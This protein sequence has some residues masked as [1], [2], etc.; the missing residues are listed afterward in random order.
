[1]KRREVFEARV[2]VFL[3]RRW[4]ER[5]GWTTVDVDVFLEHGIPVE[6]AKLIADTLVDPVTGESAVPVDWWPKLIHPPKLL[7]ARKRL[8]TVNDMTSDHA[9]AI[10]KTQRG[11]DKK[12]RAAMHAAGLT[13]NGLAEKLGI[14]SASL[15]RYRDKRPVPKAT[16]DKVKELTGFDGTWPGGIVE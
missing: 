2:G 7:H 14:S 5:I 6:Y 3:Q 16:A 8:G 4:L 9:L 12:F 15:T 11:K 13:Q 10:S 1:M